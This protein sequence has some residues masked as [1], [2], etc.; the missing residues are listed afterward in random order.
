MGGMTP[1]N[2]TIILPDGS[3]MPRLGLG[4]WRM[5]ES[6]T[7]RQDEIRAVQHAIASGLTLIDTAEMYGDGGA[8]EVVG[9][10]MR[11]ANVECDELFVVSKV[12]PWNAS[13]RGTIDACEKS[14]KRLGIGTLDLYLLHWRGE[15]PL[16]DTVE[17]F[18]QLKRDGKIRRWGVSNFDTDDMRELSTVAAPGACMVNQVYYNLAKRWSEDTLLPWQ[19][20]HGIACMA[21]SPLNQG[22]L[23]TH[24]AVKAVATRLDAT[25]VQVALAWLLSF[26]D[27]AAIP[28]SARIEGI[29]EIVGAAKL[30]LTSEDRDVLVHAFPPPHASARMETT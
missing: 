16:A 7:T 2:T 25:P 12:Y 29:D 9:A 13:R 24:R 28:K 6:A 14:L 10:A 20:K 11:L 4:T 15:H 22:S 1:M 3:T 18:E 21:Y 26:P 19:R 30:T 17:A 27:V 5:G 23:A 8:E